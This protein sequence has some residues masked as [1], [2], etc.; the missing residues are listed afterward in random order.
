MLRIGFLVDIL[1]GLWYNRGDISNHHAIVM[2]N[3]G[4][5]DYSRL[6]RILDTAISY[7]KEAGISEMR[8][9]CVSSGW[10]TLEDIIYDI[11]EI[12]DELECCIDTY[13][14]LGKIYKRVSCT[15]KRGGV[16]VSRG[17]HPDY[18]EAINS[19]D[20]AYVAVRPFAMREFAL[21]S[22]IQTFKELNYKLR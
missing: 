19:L 14:D 9:C 1:G 4:L 18:Y 10:R 17:E 2:S 6:V 7:L 16:W 22:D 13:R 12:K 21:V 20:T 8:N 11:E 15:M 5:I 3:D